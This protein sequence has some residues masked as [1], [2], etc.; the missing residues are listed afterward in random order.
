M[1]LDNT[2]HLWLLRISELRALADLG[3]SPSLATKDIYPHVLNLGVPS[4][5]TLAIVIKLVY[6]TYVHHKCALSV[7]HD[8]IGR[9][10]L[11]VSHSHTCYS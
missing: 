8:V 4:P 5:H 10:S 6:Y 2:M 9:V 11:R 3:Y 7:L 1:R